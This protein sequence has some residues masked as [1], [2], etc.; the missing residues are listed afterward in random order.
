MIIGEYN[1]R[2]VML[3]AVA[4]VERSHD[5]K[6]VLVHTTD[7]ETES[8]E[9]TEFDAVLRHT[10]QASFEANGAQLI[11]KIYDENMKACDVE[12]RAIVG[13]YIDAAGELRAVTMDGNTG[14]AAVILFADG[15]VE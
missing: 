12:L 8:F 6:K 11:T 4:R 3:S 13:F 2:S 14:D 1:R 9:G 15:H 7:G 5:F 10:V